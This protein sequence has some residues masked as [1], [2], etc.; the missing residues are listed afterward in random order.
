M[1]P[2]GRDER[3]AFEQSLSVLCARGELR[4]AATAIVERYGAEIVGFLVAVLR[5]RQA[6]AEVFAQLGLDLWSGLASFRGESSYRTWAYTLAR[7]AAH[8]YRRD[9]LRRRGAPL[10][11]CPELAEMER[12][13]RTATL[14]YL[15]TEVK[16]EV[17]RLREMLDAEDQTLLILRV[18]RAMSW[19]DIAAVM[20]GASSD[21]DERARGAATLRKRFERVKDRLRAAVTR[22]RPATA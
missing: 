6:A 14:T 16:D 5:D 19:G 3:E 17:S 7:N 1:E 9:P 21:A 20:L 13:V 8:R 2:P 18:D 15:R 10:S 22:E 12:R 4:A 11:D